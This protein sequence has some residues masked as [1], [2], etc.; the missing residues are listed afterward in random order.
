LDRIP[1][2]SETI[3]AVGY[4]PATRELEVEF[5]DGTVHL[6]SKVPPKVHAELM[7]AKSVGYY[8]FAKFRDRYSSRE[9]K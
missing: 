4:D 6:Y 2:K 7:R 8:F 3:S 9:L 1:V 5:N